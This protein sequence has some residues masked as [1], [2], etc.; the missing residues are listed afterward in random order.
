MNR[1]IIFT[2]I[3]FCFVNVISLKSQDN[4]DVS[5]QNNVF[6]IGE[7]DK[8]YE[9]LIE[10]YNTNLVKVCGKDMDL[11]YDYWTKLNSEI[12]KYA[13]KSSM[14]LIGVKLW[15]HTFWNK[16]GKIDYIF[17]YPKSS[18]RSID[19]GELK[20]VLSNFK[21]KYKSELSSNTYFSHYGSSSFKTTIHSQVGLYK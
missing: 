15:L 6:F 7:N 8:L 14:Q 9:E 21:M 18:S 13:S 5:I 19:Y 11:A 4:N 2:V 12:E 10:K 1:K 20:E 17:F 3:I 16:D